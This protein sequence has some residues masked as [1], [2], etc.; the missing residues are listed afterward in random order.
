V[1]TQVAVGDLLRAGGDVVERPDLLQHPER[2]FE[3]VDA[4]ADLAQLRGLLVHADAPAAL[5][6]RGGS[7]EACQ[8]GSRHLCTTLLQRRH[9][10]RR[11]PGRG[12]APG[13]A[14]V[15]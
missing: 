11:R 3:Q 14:T 15:R 6:E 13:H 5:R 12:S 4:G 1:V 10:T 2:V 9:C 8:P 7:R